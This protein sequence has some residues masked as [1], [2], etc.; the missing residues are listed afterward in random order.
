[1]ESIEKKEYNES[2]LNYWNNKLCIVVLTYNRPQR[3]DYYI[4]SYMKE[5]ADYGVDFIV[6]D[7][8]T[9][10]ETEKI[11]N[12]QIARGY[13]NLFYARY[14]GTYDG[15]S[16]DNKVI[17][18]YRIYCNK[19]QYVW[20]C[21]DGFIINF[22]KIKTKLKQIL[23]KSY[24][25]IVAD[26]AIRTPEKTNL[27]REYTD[28][29][30]LLEDQ[31]IRMVTLG[32]LIISSDFCKQMID[33]CPID[34]S[35]YT[36]W[37]AIAPFCYI[38][39]RT[40]SAVAFY[41]DIFTYHPIRI[42]SSFWN[43]NGD[44]VW[45]WAYRWCTILDLL[46][47]VYDGSKD[48]L[49]RIKM[50]D[51]NP[52]GNPQLLIMKANKGLGFSKVLQYRE[53]LK[54]ATEQSYFK[55]VLISLIPIPSMYIKKVFS[56]EN[57][58]ISKLTFRS[59]NVVKKLINLFNL[60]DK[61]RFDFIK[62]QFLKIKQRLLP[63]S[64][65]SFHERISHVSKQ[66]SVTNHSLNGIKQY[67]KK[68]ELQF[69]ISINKA[70]ETLEE[71]KI[72]YFKSLPYTDQATRNIQIIIT[73]ILRDFD[74]ICQKYSLNY[75]LWGGSL[76]GAVRHDGFIPWDDD[77]DVVMPREDFNRFVE[78]LSSSDFGY[79]LRYCY[80]LGHPTWTCQIPKLYI[81][82]CEI[83]LFLD[84]FPFDWTNCENKIIA[85]KEYFKRRKAIENDVNCYLRQMNLRSFE[86]E[87][88]PHYLQEKLNQIFSMHTTTE[89]LDATHLMW[90][91]DMHK[92]DIG[93]ISK[94]D[95]FPLRK[96]TFDGLEVNIPYNYDA[97][98]K[99][100]YGDYYSFPADAYSNYHSKFFGYY[101]LKDEIQNLVN[102]L[103]KAY[104]NRL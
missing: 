64:S 38:S 73:H 95:I 85:Q 1:M 3:I 90:G 15:K 83:P 34:E 102:E 86:S 67:I 21:R 99:M 97:C 66:V 55:I 31:C 33:A 56:D 43:E 74:A 36:L 51:F 46:P 61:N 59:I 93:Y 24:D 54:K 11:V 70:G 53:F 35:N 62:N 28:C 58:I 89:L 71:T 42:R 91:A 20:L 50:V 52:F 16:I 96:H 48:S 23:D 100:L 49:Y 41:D 103:E 19:Y 32:T 72:S 75:W 4:K 25:F 60:K 47:S 30:K 5:Y 22:T 57:S 77:A 84:I 101:D 13:D 2:V 69:W 63:P 12:E 45:Q 39:D 87:I 79:E 10:N 88:V 26:S 76:L 37:Q 98:L 68:S 17:E 78:I 80:D 14:E 7:S 8:S 82:N 94:N 81:K 40:F 9:N 65:K 29:K 92:A 27:V 44:A 104:S 18:A 6:Y